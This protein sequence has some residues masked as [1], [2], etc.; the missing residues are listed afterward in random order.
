[1]ERR[2]KQVKRE[3]KM[4]HSHRD[5]LEEV[6]RTGKKTVGKCGKTEKRHC[7]WSYRHK[8]TIQY[9]SQEMQERGSPKNDTSKERF[10]MLSLDIWK[11]RKKPY[12]SGGMR[13]EYNMLSDSHSPKQGEDGGGKSAWSTT[14]SK[15]FGGG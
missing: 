3:R 4:T 7:S 13:G 1:M 2:G 8:A 6:E 14:F 12:G 10:A 11:K 15:S 9:P 5:T